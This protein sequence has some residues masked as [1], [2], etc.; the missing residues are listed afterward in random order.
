ME[1]FESCGIKVE[2][3]GASTK[4]KYRCLSDTIYSKVWRE[5]T[6][7]SGMTLMLALT[8]LFISKIATHRR[9]QN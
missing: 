1:D 7:R 6:L 9:H 5:E 3:V 2:K 8:L 4:V